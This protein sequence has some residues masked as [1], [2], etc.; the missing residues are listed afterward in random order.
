MTLIR[1][2]RSS[3][4]SA[5]TSDFEPSEKGDFPTSTSCQGVHA[6]LHESEEE[7]TAEHHLFFR[8]FNFK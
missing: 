6:V 1:K 8:E 3:R 4:A 5:E 7:N 2:G